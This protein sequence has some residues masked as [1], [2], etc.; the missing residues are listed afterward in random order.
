MQGSAEVRRKGLHLRGDVHGDQGEH[1]LRFG[2]IQGRVRGPGK[3]VGGCVG[4]A[5]GSEGLPIDEE[6]SGGLS[7]E[8]VGL[9]PDHRHK[10]PSLHKFGS[11]ELRYLANIQ[12]TPWC[13]TSI[14]NFAVV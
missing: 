12:R 7:A 14:T 11:R 4:A 5:A 13:L 3:K 9:S 6:L 2:R 1:Q 10:T 8:D